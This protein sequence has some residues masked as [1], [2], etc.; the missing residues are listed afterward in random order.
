MAK[1]KVTFLGHASFKFE[2]EQGTTIYFDAWLDDNPTAKMKVAQVRKADIVIATH[3]HNDHIGNSFAICRKTKAKFVGN[4]EMCLIA[5]QHGLKLGTRALPMNPGGT[6]KVKDV[7]I[8]MVQA[9]HSL[10]MSPELEKGEPPKDEY[11]RAD[12]AVTGFVLAFDNGITIYD[13]ADTCLFSDMQLI[14]QMYNPQIVVMPVG[15]K[16]TMGV[17]EAARAASFIRPDVVVPCHYGATMGQPVDIGELQQAVRF[18]SPNTEVAPMKVGQTMTFTK[19][20]FN[21]S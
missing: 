19:S 2:S 8:T 10:S 13:T 9:I 1:V 3:G 4:Y 12:S 17:R 16:F 7:N 15:G 18:L 5:E 20:S 14:G 21:L 6:V 11:F